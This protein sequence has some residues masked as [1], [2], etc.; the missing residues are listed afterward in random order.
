ME[1]TNTELAD[2]SEQ[3]LYDV[4][5]RLAK[6]QTQSMDN[7]RSKSENAPNTPRDYFNPDIIHL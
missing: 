2:T 6:L 7:F 1:Q 4:W 3:T 5:V